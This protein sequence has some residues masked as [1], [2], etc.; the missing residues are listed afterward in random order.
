MA[1]FWKFAIR[2]YSSEF[3]RHTLRGPEG[4]CQQVRGKTCRFSTCRIIV[5]GFQ[6]QNVRGQW[7]IR[8]RIG[9]NGLCSN[10]PNCESSAVIGRTSMELAGSRFIR[11]ELEVANQPMQMRP[12]STTTSSRLSCRMFFDHPATHPPRCWMLDAGC[13][14]LDAGCWMLD[15]GCWMHRERPTPMWLDPIS[16]IRHQGGLERISVSEAPACP[17]RR[18]LQPSLSPDPSA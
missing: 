1:S 7:P 13:W 10:G 2:Q 18:T 15:A 5:N 14:M 8:G 9:G 3:L 4:Y 17:L 16:N 12:D 11:T 6:L